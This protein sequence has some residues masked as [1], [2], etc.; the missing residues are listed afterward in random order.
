MRDIVIPLYTNQEKKSKQGSSSKFLNHP[1]Q[2]NSSVP[3]LQSYFLSHLRLR[4]MQSPLPHCHSHSMHSAGAGVVSTT[5]AWM[6]C[7]CTLM[8]CK[9]AKSNRSVCSYLNVLHWAAAAVFNKGKSRQA[10]LKEEANLL[11]EGEHVTDGIYRASKTL[12]SSS[13]IGFCSC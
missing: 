7:E 4:S 8:K 3:S 11:L 9:V 6:K 2:S 10:S 12:M 5:M 1:P 13:C